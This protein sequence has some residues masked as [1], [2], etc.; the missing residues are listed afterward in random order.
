MQT[1]ALKKKRLDTAPNTTKTRRTLRTKQ[2]LTHSKERVAPVLDIRAG[3]AW[4]WVATLVGL[5]ALAGILVLRF[6]QASD[7]GN[8]L[9]GEQLAVFL[10]EQTATQSTRVQDTVEV[11]GFVP[12]EFNNASPATAYVVYYLDGGPVFKTNERP[13]RFSW[14]SQRHPNGEH[15][16]AAIAYGSDNQP[17]GGSQRTLLVNNTGGVVGTLRNV[18]SAPAQWLFQF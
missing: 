11:S 2:K 7:F 16:V 13:F 14:D 6:S 9:L 1:I 17:L 18:I 4:W 5:V 12:F 8:I 15:T 10:D 3:F